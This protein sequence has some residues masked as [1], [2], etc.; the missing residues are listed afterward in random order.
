MEEL[1]AIINRCV[2]GESNR[3]QA[4]YEARMVIGEYM[5]AQRGKAQAYLRGKTGIRLI[6]TTPEMERQYQSMTEVYLADFERI[7]DDSLRNG[8]VLE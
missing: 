6:T 8:G 4:I 3:E 1:K 2:A 7:L 5:T